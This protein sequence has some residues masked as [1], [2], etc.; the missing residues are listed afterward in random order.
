MRRKLSNHNPHHHKKRQHVVAV[1]DEARSFAFCSLAI[2]ASQTTKYFR[3]GQWEIKRQSLLNKSGYA[4]LIRS[5]LLGRSVGSSLVVLEGY[6]GV[7]DFVGI[8]FNRECES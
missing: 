6:R 7:E 8:I 1:F 4:S 5:F 3:N 2:I